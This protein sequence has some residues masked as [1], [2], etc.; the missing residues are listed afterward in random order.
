MS[1]LGRHWR[2]ELSL[3]VS[4]WING[5]LISLVMIAVVMSLSDYVT[6]VLPGYE[7][8][9]FTAPEQGAY[10]ILLFI[11][12][13]IISIW[14]LG[15]IW[16]SAAN[17]KVKTNTKFWGTA[18][19][20]IVLIGIVR[21]CISGVES[22]PILKH[23]WSL[24]TTT[25]E[26]TDYNLTYHEDA[27]LLELDGSFAHGLSRDVIAHLREHPQTTAI[28]LN[29]VGG[30]LDEGFGLHSVIE[31]HNLIT[32][33]TQECYSACTS[34][35][36]AGTERYVSNYASLGFHIET[37]LV[38]EFNQDPEQSQSAM[39]T[40]LKDFGVSDL[41]LANM[42]AAVGA[43]LYLP[44]HATLL[45]ER[46]ITGTKN[47]FDE[48]PR[49]EVELTNE[50]ELEL[51]QELAN[52]QLYNFLKEYEPE[53]YEE[54]I[55]KIRIIIKNGGSSLEAQRLGNSMMAPLL[56]KRMPVTSGRGL[57]AFMDGF[58]LTA[59]ELNISNPRKCMA[60]LEPA[61]YGQFDF[62]GSVSEE[63]FKKA[64]ELTTLAIKE[65]Y[66]PVEE[67]IDEQAGAASLQRLAALGT[68]RF[69]LLGTHPQDEQGQKATCQAFIDL[70][71]AIRNSPDAERHNVTRYMFSLQNQGS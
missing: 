15:G 20:I 60:Y 1:Y 42:E 47:P 36:L 57:D 41:F 34:A 39:L 51:L 54:L 49:T 44:D 38:P 12:P 56:E 29:S 8:T 22:I 35:F 32:F 48:N 26:Y 67:E 13:N 6:K 31:K 66:P 52:S 30:W 18:A 50:Q 71:S 70:F 7:V 33:S 28:L 40:Q 21:L 3:P 64:E 4:Y 46:I 23:N 69:D 5:S 68:I 11:I 25:S 65:S 59:T 43:D 61:V 58:I 2:G 37:T 62:I 27:K 19:Q 9:R 55:T 24:V 53:V 14:Q 10:L 45:S 63:V 17:H 16:R